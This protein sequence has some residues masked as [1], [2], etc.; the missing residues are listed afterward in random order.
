MNLHSAFDILEND[1]KLPQQFLKG[2]LQIYT[3]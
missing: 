2:I 1:L 3:N